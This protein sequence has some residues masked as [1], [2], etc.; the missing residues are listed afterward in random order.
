MARIGIE[1]EDAVWVAGGVCCLWRATGAWVP[2][3]DVKD[4]SSR[5]VGR[6]RPDGGTD[7]GAT[8]AGRLI[9]RV[10]CPSRSAGCGTHRFNTSLNTRAITGSGHSDVNESVR[11]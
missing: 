2:G 8:W 6:R 4:I 7:A 10:E 9:E 1:C 11:D 5:V 3:R